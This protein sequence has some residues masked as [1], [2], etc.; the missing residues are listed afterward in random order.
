M[1]SFNNI[2]KQDYDKKIKVGD[3]YAFCYSP[4]KLKELYPE[5][6]YSISGEARNGS[7]ENQNKYDEKQLK[8]LQKMKGT[9]PKA[10]RRTR[11]RVRDRCVGI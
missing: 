4:K 1:A 7:K 10:I 6:N 5:G 8:K 3:E 11:K 2:F 9:S